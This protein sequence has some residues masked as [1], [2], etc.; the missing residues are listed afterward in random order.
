M[1]M[2]KQ[3]VEAKIEIVNGMLGFDA[4][5]VSWNTVGALRLQGAYGGYAVHRTVSTSGGIEDLTSYGTLRE[6]ATFLSGMIA[7]LRIGG[8]K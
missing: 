2:S 3:H 7:A 5:S 8:G 4:D 6:C 1:R